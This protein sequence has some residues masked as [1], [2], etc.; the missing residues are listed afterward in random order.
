MD[1]EFDPAKRRA[2]LADR[3]LDMADAAEVFAD[4]ILTLADTR[5]DYGEDRFMTVGYLR[6]RMVIVIWT[7]RGTSRRIISLRKANEREQ[8]AYRSSL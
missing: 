8:D 1:I 3:G 2:T 6:D 5:L 7:M 4:A